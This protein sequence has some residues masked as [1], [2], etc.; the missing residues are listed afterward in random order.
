[1]EADS[2]YAWLWSGLISTGLFAAVWKAGHSFISPSLIPDHYRRFSEKDK[3]DWNSRYGSTLHALLIVMYAANVLFLTDAF[4]DSFMAKAMRGPIVLRVTNA[5]QKALGISIGYFINDITIMTL[6]YPELG[7][8]EML[9]HHWAAFLSV[10]AAAISHQ[11]HQYTLLLL[12]TELTTPFINARWVFDKL[13]W[14]NTQQYFVNGIALFVTWTLGREVLFL[15]FFTVLWQHRSEMALC[16]FPIRLLVLGVPPLLFAL[17]TFWFTKICRGVFKLLRGQLKKDDDLGYR[18]PPT[19][20]WALQSKGLP[21][22]QIAFTE[23]PRDRLH[24]S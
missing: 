10:A 14:R 13:G 24:V 18:R 15:W 21:S 9:L 23:L 4:E 6:N 12:F 17:N 1:M 16:N 22:D 8:W 11:A 20:P 19:V 7:G 5:S 3:L 2:S